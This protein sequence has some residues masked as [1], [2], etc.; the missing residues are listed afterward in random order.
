M[1]AIN[2]NNSDTVY[3]TVTSS[4][5]VQTLIA[6]NGNRVGLYIHNAST[7]I[8]YIKVDGDATTSN[9]TAKLEAGAL[10][11]MPR[12]YFTDQVTGIWASANGQANVTEISTRSH[13]GDN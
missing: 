1:P 3:A 6:E 11:E 5:S 13:Q 4:A 10:Y 12:N 9:Y 8:L 7:A 2:L